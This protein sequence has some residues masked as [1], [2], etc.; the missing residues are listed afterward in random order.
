MCECPATAHEVNG[1]CLTASAPFE[2]RS[3]LN[4]YQLKVNSCDAP[5]FTPVVQT[6][7]SNFVWD[8]QVQKCVCP[9]YLP[10]NDGSKCIS[11]PVD[12]SFD[13]ISKSC[14]SNSIDPSAAAKIP[15]YTTT[16]V[17]GPAV[18]DPSTIAKVPIYSTTTVPSSVPSSS[19]SNTPVYS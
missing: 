14:Q 19:Y 4:T 15:V 9:S 12:T 7:T 5:S 17:Q 16:T 18:I 3:D 11:C 13:P 2:W 8:N 10:F 6:C 1:E